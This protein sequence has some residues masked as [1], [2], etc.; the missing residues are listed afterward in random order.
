MTTLYADLETYSPIPIK[1]GVHAYAEQA[2]ILLFAY[3]LESEDVRVWDCTAEDMPEDLKE[4]LADPTIT[5][6]FHNSHFDRTILKHTMPNAIAG[7]IERWFDTMVQAYW[8]S[9]PGSLGEL[10]EIFNLDI[11]D[12]KDKAGKQLIQLFCK[13]RPKNSK[14]RRATRETHPAE[15][16]RFKQYATLDIKAMRVLRSKMPMWNAKDNEK[17]LWYLDQKINDRGFEVDIELT[18]SAIKAI[19][20]QK[21]GL[22][23]RTL[24]LTEGEVSS[25]TQRDA[26]LS[27]LLST[28]GV[29]LPD[30]TASTIERRLSDPELPEAVKELLSTRLIANATSSSKYKKLLGAVSSD[31]RLRGTLQ[32]C[33]ATRTGRWAGRTFQPQNLPRPTLKQHDI[34]L[35]IEA[36]KSD[37]AEL[38]Y[39]SVTELAS[40]ALRGC[41]VAPKGKKLVVSDLSNIEGRVLAWLAGEDWKIKAFADFDKGEGHDLYNLAYAKS[42]GIKPE[43]VTKDQ[44]QIGKVQELGLGYEGGVGAFLTFASAYR[45]DLNDLAKSA[46]IP[47]HIKE[48]STRAWEWA[49]K[50]KRTYDLTKEIFIVCDSI[51][52]MWREAHPNICSLWKGVDNAVRSAIQKPHSI[53]TVG[54]L[55]V[56]RQGA[57]LRIELPSGRYLCYPGI[58]IDDLNR[59]TYMG[60]DTYTRKWKRLTTYSGKLVENITQATAR[61]VMAV[62]MQ[63]I[64][65][66]GYSTILTV[67]DEVITEAPDT[68]EYSHQNLSEL[69]ST[70]P[71]WATGLPLNA[72]GFEAYRYKKD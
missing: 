21:K 61:D 3:A 53:Y 64:E 32:F 69:L 60:I 10:S 51:K 47:P 45:L 70:Q 62:N 50:Q 6:C 27:H 11:G 19:D 66:H 14:L 30:L 29:T 7:G 43:K 1:N 8:H 4:Y 35:G 67:H 20:K 46:K 33:G 63:L 36:L 26:L 42:F 23:K 58:K 55:R 38:V 37:V 41:I 72:G 48:A 68:T 28:Y 54:R 2:E 44:R 9:L 71:K 16:E 65:R 22:A 59:I 15:W 52:R 13:P 57:W 56:L 34:D 5:L 31:G 39:D 49:V 18:Q 17:Q 12:A 24:V 25:T 40:A